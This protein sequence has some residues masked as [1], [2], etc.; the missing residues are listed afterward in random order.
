M[1]RVET[2]GVIGFM[3]FILVKIRKYFDCTK[4]Q[5]IFED[6][7]TGWEGEHHVM[8]LQMKSGKTAEY[9]GNKHLKKN[10]TEKATQ[11]VAAEAQSKETNMMVSSQSDRAEVM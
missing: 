2:V 4:G 3:F 6:C 1:L 11:N 5:F 10:A 8:F 7:V 9:D